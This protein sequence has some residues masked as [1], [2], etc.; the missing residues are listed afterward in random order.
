[1]PFSRRKYWFTS[2]PTIHLLRNGNF[3]ETLVF[4]SNLSPQKWKKKPAEQAFFFFAFSSKQR[5]VR[6]T[7]NKIKRKKKKKTLVLQP[8]RNSS[9]GSI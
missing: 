8:I 2:W 7:H 1:M 3:L 5:Q 9:L 4:H 6:V